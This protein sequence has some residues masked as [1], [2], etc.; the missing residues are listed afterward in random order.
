MTDLKEEY[1]S[2]YMEELSY[3]RYQQTLS[4]YPHCRDPEHPGCELCREEEND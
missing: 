2:E 4:R 3:K 1:Y